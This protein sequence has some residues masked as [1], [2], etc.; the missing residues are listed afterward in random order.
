MSGPVSNEQFRAAE[1][2]VGQYL[3]QGVGNLSDAQK[4][5]LASNLAVMARYRDSSSV[6]ADPSNVLKALNAL[7]GD[8]GLTV[9]MYYNLMTGKPALPPASTNAPEPTTSQGNEWFNPSSLS[10]YLQNNS[11]LLNLLRDMHSMTEKQGYE[12]LL[13]YADAQ[14]SVADLTY[15]S[16]KKDAEMAKWAMIGAIVGLGVGLASAG[17]GAGGAAKFGGAN[18]WSALGKGVGPA[19]GVGKTAGDILDNAM[20]SQILVEKG[21][22]DRDKVLAETHARIDMDAREASNQMS[23]DAA[24]Q[25]DNIR[26]TSESTSRETRH[27]LNFSN[28]G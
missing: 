20:K 11:E 1:Q 21:E 3:G 14:K 27:N 24:S 16:A 7:P 15:E 2:S 25:A 22:I 10:I 19:M 17:L 9:G 28:R 13:A 26:Q 5:D 18:F 6:N 8:Q 12:A 23:Q 4:S